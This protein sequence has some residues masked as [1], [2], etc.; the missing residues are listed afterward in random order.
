MRPRCRMR[1]LRAAVGGHLPAVVSGHGGA[2]V[3]VG[4]LHQRQAHAAQR[5]AQRAQLAPRE[6]LRPPPR[7]GA[8]ARAQPAQVH[9]WV[10]NTHCTQCQ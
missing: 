3:G 9:V 7:L 1:M 10:W 4:Q 6:G 5:A 2:R 8:A